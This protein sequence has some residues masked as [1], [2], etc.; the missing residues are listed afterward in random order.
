MDISSAD[1]LS[2]LEGVNPLIASI[3]SSSE[4]LPASVSPANV[5]FAI[6]EAYR[7]QQVAFNDTVAA[8][9]YINTVG[10]FAPQVVLFDGDGNPYQDL[11]STV[12]VR[13]KLKTDAIAGSEGTTK[14]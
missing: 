14:I 5:L 8:P 13:Q 12:R 9:P 11:V 10:A 3:F 4:T 7:R 2:K 1:F 6:A